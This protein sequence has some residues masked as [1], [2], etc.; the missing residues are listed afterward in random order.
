[1]IA[2]EPF[3][4]SDFF[5]Q[6]VCMALC[7]PPIFLLKYLTFVF[8]KKDT[9]AHKMLVGSGEIVCLAL[10]SIGLVVNA[11]I[12]LPD[13]GIAPVAVGVVCA[14]LVGIVVLCQNLMGGRKRR[15]TEMEKAELMDM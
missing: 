14:T 2:Y 12:F 1:M 9:F 11:Y 15:L 6:L 5:K 10:L 3:I 13:S 4:S 8:P 7:L